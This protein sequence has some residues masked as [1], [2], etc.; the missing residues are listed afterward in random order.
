MAKQRPNL[1]PV[2]ATLNLKGGVGKTTVSA[3]VFREFYRLFS[4]PTLLI[5]FDPQFNLSQTVFNRARYD[6]LREAGQTIMA[7]ME[8][9]PSPSLFRITESAGPPPNPE[10]IST[11]L[12]YIIGHTHVNLQ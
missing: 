2:I 7:A 4:V 8:A 1:G 9:L 6:M 5:D 10:A 3:H 12:K 11:Q